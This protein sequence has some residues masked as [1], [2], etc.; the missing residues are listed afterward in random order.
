MNWKYR[1]TLTLALLLFL[2]LTAGLLMPGTA[3]AAE[4]TG[5]LTISLGEHDV[6]R[7]Y[8]EED[9]ANAVEMS[10][11]KIASSD[12][13]GGWEVDSR[14]DKYDIAGAENKLRSGDDSGVRNILDDPGFRQ[15]ALSGTPFD[16]VLMNADNEFKFS[17]LPSGIYYAI[18]TQGPKGLL[19]H[20]LV[21]IPFTYSTNELYS[22]RVGAK[23]LENCE[24]PLTA[25]KRMAGRD[26]HEGD[27]FTFM[28]SGHEV[29][30]FGKAPM[31]ERTSVTIRPANGSLSLIDFGNILF[32][33][34]DAGKTYEYTIWEEVTKT[35][36]ER[37]REQFI[38]PDTSRQKV[39]V[40]VE[41][42]EN[43]KLKITSTTTGETPLVV[44]NTYQF[45]TYI[46]VTAFKE[47]IG[48]DFIEGDSW[49]F[50]VIRKDPDAPKLK[51]SE[52]ITT[53]KDAWP[54]TI[55]PTEG[56][57]AEVHLGYLHFNEQDI[58]R[59]YHY[60][61]AESGTV[62]GVT[63]DRTKPLDV[64]VRYN[65][66]THQIEVV[67]SSGDQTTNVPALS[68]EEM[69]SRTDSVTF[70]NTYEAERNITFRGKKTVE[71]LHLLNRLMEPNEFLFEIR[72]IGEDGKVLWTDYAYND[73]EGNIIYP[74]I[75]YT[76]ADVGTHIY[77]IS[78]VPDTIDQAIGI[79]ETVHTVK[80]RVS[81]N[82]DGTLSVTPLRNSRINYTHPYELDFTNEVLTGNLLVRKML[83]TPTANEEF[84]F[85]VEMSR[86]GEPVNGTYEGVLYDN[87]K[88]NAVEGGVTFENGRTTF[89]LRG[90][91]SL[92]IQGIL[93]GTEYTV[94][95][96]M[97]GEQQ[98]SYVLSSLPNETYGQTGVIST[99][100]VVARFQNE[101]LVGDLIISKK[102]IDAT[103]I[104]ADKK[105]TFTIT[106]DDPDVIIKGSNIVFVM[107]DGTE[108]PYTAPQFTQ[109]SQYK[110]SVTVKTVAGV[111]VKIK[112]LPTGVGYTIIEKDT[113]YFKLDG[114]VNDTAVIT[115]DG[116]AAEFI[117]RRDVKP[118]SLTVY[119]TVE[120]AA[121]DTTA[122]TF[123]VT[124]DEWDGMK[125]SGTYGDMEFVD[126]VATF[127]LRSG[128][129]M[130]ATGL[131]SG[132]SYRVEENVPSG[133]SMQS[134]GSSGTINADAELGPDRDVRFI[135]TK[136]TTPGGGGGGGGGGNPPTRATATPAPTPEEPPEPGDEPTPTPE[137]EYTSVEGM[138]TWED[139]DNA[140]GKR[141]GSITIHLFADSSAAY[142][143]ID[144]RTVTAEDGWR[145]SFTNLP[146]LDSYNLPIT[147]SIVEEPVPGYTTTYSGYNVINS[148]QTELI[149]A[150]VIKKWNDDPDHH[151]MRPTSLTATLYGNNAVVTTVVLN[152]GNG[153]RATVDDLPAYR[154]GERITY[155][156][157]EEEVL[158][159][160]L[161]DTSTNGTATTFTNTLWQ[162][163]PPP[164]DTPPGP[165]PGIPEDEIDDYGTPLGLGIIINH[166]GDC[167][168]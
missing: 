59:T 92:E 98:T 146:V 150:T 14:F 87:G 5:D 53:A 112:G 16:K 6:I 23:V 120:G 86:N 158:G 4:Q 149:S 168:D 69:A 70:K 68:E 31:P 159:Y 160:V 79:D 155:T 60:T 125:I 100:G 48:R 37:F 144:S 33:H 101:R 36:E 45:A 166:V 20:S 115:T 136:V 17:G 78:E 147:Y 162:L 28:V 19:V 97:T 99:D 13:K 103:E 30:T 132:I 82:M 106:F 74:T 135:N 118:V 111:P 24:F 3:Q 63:N 84:A 138:K 8:L 121:N 32:T 54:V 7:T 38:V 47:L 75:H 56:S 55:T 164:N 153:W 44:T 116:V 52:D 95:E 156:W 117:N 81:D 1:R 148:M 21:P 25:V 88:T 143:E 129:S 142:E 71:N 34:D 157:Q 108:K 114:K 50:Q 128:Q 96:Q 133:Y 151:P 141:P 89:S 152:E 140:A 77:V 64:E 65:P 41:E 91:Q 105:F 29:N 40:T 165:R 127:T 90:N 18:M 22:L 167:F 15:I 123:T 93:V 46:P 124:L 73:A 12:G 57:L 51:D 113:P 9:N 80:V 83:R 94:T 35:D 43:G 161:T 26:F 107:E 131:P 66:E 137:P 58:G 110:G 109:E 119:K 27:E 139:D 39:T 130:T 134:I 49:T 126:G 145:W 122:F 2:S 61:I 62:R 11:F 42:A 102:M 154:N 67:S 72:E 163:V 76:L 85:T 10:I 104:D